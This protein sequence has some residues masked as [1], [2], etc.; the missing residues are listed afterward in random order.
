MDVI[1]EYPLTPRTGVIVK[2][3]LDEEASNPRREHYLEPMTHIVVF[4]VGNR[5][6]GLN[7]LQDINTPEDFWWEIWTEYFPHL[8]PD[9][10][11]EYEDLSSVTLE[12]LEAEPFP[13][14]I[15]NLHIQPSWDPQLKVEPF[16][17]DP[18]QHGGY[19]FATH[20]DIEKMGTSPDWLE[21]ALEAEV[22]EFNAYLSGNVFGI[23]VEDLSQDPT[24]R[25]SLWGI[26]TN[27]GDDF[28]TEEL[29]DFLEGMD[30]TEAELA[31]LKEQLGAK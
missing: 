4:D 22:Y 31:T 24:T 12:H 16:S 17:L 27:S 25:D 2:V 21:R 10:A 13:G 8:I 30:V 29:L 23:I 3:V 11:E 15:R 9:D 6:Q 19:I 18:P 14:I 7:E 26:Y 28:S 5:D 1:A 20:T